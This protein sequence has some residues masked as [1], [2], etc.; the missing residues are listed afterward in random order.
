M[1]RHA[2]DP[3]PSV[4]TA[5]PGVSP[6]VES[7]I[8]RALQKVPADR[9]ASVGEFAAALTGSQPT[10]EKPPR[11]LAVPHPARGRVVDR[12]R[13][14]RDGCRCRAVLV[15]EAS[16]RSRLD[17][18]GGGPLPGRQQRQWPSVSARRHDGPLRGEV[19]RRDRT[20]SGGSAP[21]DRTLGRGGRGSAGPARGRGAATGE[22]ARG[23]SV[24]HRQH[25]RKCG[26]HSAE[27]RSARCLD[28]AHPATG[29][30]G[31]PARQP[32]VSGGPSRRPAAGAG[33]GASVAAA[34]QSHQRVAAG[35]SGLPRRPGRLP[36]RGELRRRPAFQS[37]AGTRLGVRPGGTRARQRLEQRG[38]VPGREGNEGGLASQ[39]PPELAR[40]DHPRGP[41]TPR[42][43]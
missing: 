35:H 20:E 32:A 1:A 24:A 3:V 15:A 7:A 30:G 22:G 38:W 37:G 33:R 29:D 6:A 11:H 43:S 10:V 31:R 40:P 18:R 34:R 17:S 8:H 9:F 14:P 23:R 4:R 25:R 26:A 42:S 5:R 27:R 28:W 21:G 19:H 39:G 36:R 2:L 41:R 12:A 16:G 13:R